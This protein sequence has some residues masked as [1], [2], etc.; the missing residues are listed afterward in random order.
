[1]TDETIKVLEPVAAWLVGLRN[2]YSNKSYLNNCPP[3]ESTLST[4]KNFIY[5]L[6][7]FLVSLSKTLN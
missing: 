4:L 7:E 3:F 6:V 1:M 5:K 2:L